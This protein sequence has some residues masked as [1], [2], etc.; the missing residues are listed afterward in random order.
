[1]TRVV[2]EI[3]EDEPVVSSKLNLQ[4]T[5]SEN[6]FEENHVLN[7]Y[8]IIRALKTRHRNGISYLRLSLAA[9]V[10]ILAIMKKF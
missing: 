3:L 10:L 6:V 8:I 1:M 4:G 7:V 5:Y 2:N 9:V